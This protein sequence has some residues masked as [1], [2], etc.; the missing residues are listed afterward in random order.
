MPSL[1]LT[2]CG[3]KK[4]AVIKAVREITGFG[5]KEA[6]D[7]VENLPAMVLQDPDLS[8][9]EDALAFLEDAGASADIR[10]DQ[11]TLSPAPAADSGGSHLWTVRLAQIGSRKI[12]VIKAV[13]SFSGLGLKETKD[14]VESAPVVVLTSPDEASAYA[15]YEALREAQAKAELIAPE[16]VEHDAPVFTLPES[17]QLKL[18]SFGS[19]KIAVIKAVRTATGFGLKE[20]KEL[21]DRVPSELPPLEEDRAQQLIDAINAAGGK[22]EHC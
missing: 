10:G 4:I 1:V 5:L 19:S 9:L 17:V 13:R 3:R 11:P 8:L 6:K 12:A 16:H 7:L 22:I 21:V 15:A 2:Q 20:A 18:V 14:L